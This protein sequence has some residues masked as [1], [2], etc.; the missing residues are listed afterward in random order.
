VIQPSHPLPES[1]EPGTFYFV[2]SGRREPR[3]GR[4]RGQED[5][6]D[7]PS[8]RGPDDFEPV[9]RPEKYGI[10]VAE[11][12]PLRRA[13]NLALLELQ[14]DGTSQSLYTKWFSPSP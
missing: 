10:V 7:R 1:T 14:D 6:R 3:V 2:V 5:G 8:I 11:G 4:P 13:I 9:F 12:S